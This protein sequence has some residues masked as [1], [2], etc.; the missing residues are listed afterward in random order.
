M[1]NVLKEIVAP[2]RHLT[3]DNATIMQELSDVKRIQQT[4]PTNQ[5]GERTM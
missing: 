2:L 3:Q 4:Q 1:V 5:A